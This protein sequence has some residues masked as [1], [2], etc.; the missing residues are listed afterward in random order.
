LT[1]AETARKALEAKKGKNV[2]LLD[3]RGLSEVTD[4]YLVVSGSNPPHLKAMYNEVRHTLKTAGAR[5]YRRAGAP[6]SGWLVLDYVDVVIHIF[7]DR[8]REYYAV[9]ELWAGAPRPAPD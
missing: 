2:S 6:D 4:Y 1:L 5:C 9:E 7:L 3:V 8:A